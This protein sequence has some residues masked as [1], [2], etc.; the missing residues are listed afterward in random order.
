MKTFHLFLLLI[1]VQTP[2]IFSQKKSNIKL[3]ATYYYIP[4]VH[5]N[6]NGINLLDHQENKTGFKLLPDDWCNACI[7][8]TVIVNKN[9]KKHILN[10]AGRSKKSQYDCRK[11]KKYKNYDGHEKTGK[12]LWKK[13]NGYGIGVNG[14]HL[15]P[16]RTIAVDHTIIPYGSVLYIPKAIG[17]E[18]IDMN[19]KKKKHD[20][21]FFAADTGSKIKGNHIDFFIGVVKENP[22]NFIK[23]NKTKPFNAL[24]IYDEKMKSKFEKLHKL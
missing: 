19:N 21:Y 13:S 11:C 23:S 9:Q 4:E 5:H 15:I 6:E 17:I 7:Q 3:W 8:G 20:G 12:V 10:Y 22:F 14:Y 16:F 24:L 18:Y 1:F 2:Q